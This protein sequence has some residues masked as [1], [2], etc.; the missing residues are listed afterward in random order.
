[1]LCNGCGGHFGRT[2]ALGEVSLCFNCDKDPDVFLSKKCKHGEL[3]RLCRLCTRDKKIE[4]LFALL[5]E[6]YGSVQFAYNH[7]G[8]DKRRKWLDDYDKM[9]G[10]A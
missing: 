10:K 6:A 3:D 7:W 5:D 2:V 4:V 8:D 1:M 9:K